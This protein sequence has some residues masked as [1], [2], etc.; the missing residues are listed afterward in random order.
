[1]SA[2]LFALFHLNP[3]QFPAT[4]ML[5]LFLGWIMIRTNNI[6]LAILGHSIHNFLV[7]LSITFWEEI[8]SNAFYLMGK[9]KVYYVSALV[10]LLSALLIFVLSQK[11][12]KNKKSV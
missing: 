1:M 8:H 2:L 7:L 12:V 4:F 10:V 11:W 5:G 3:W 6:I 9:V